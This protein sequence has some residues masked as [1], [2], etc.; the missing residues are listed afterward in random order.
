MDLVNEDVLNLVNTLNDGNC[1]L[2]TDNKIA[3][4]L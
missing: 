3:M 1:E 2:S 4:H